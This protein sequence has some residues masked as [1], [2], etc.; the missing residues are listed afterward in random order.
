MRLP[1]NVPGRR[2]LR[3]LAPA[4][5]LC[6]APARAQVAEDCAGRLAR[7][8]QAASRLAEE[9][10]ALKAR[11]GLLEGAPALGRDEL[12]RRNALRLQGI[13]RDVKAQRQTM[14]DFERYVKWMSGSLSSYSRYIEAGTAA[15]TFAKYLPVPYAGQAGAFVKFAAHF[16][17]SLNATSNAIERYLQ[18]SQQF[19][20]RAEGL[21][22]SKPKE[23]EVADLGR[24]ADEQLLKATGDVQ[25]KLG[26]V[27]ELSASALS[28][29]QGMEQ[30]LSSADEA[31]SKTKQFVTRK[32]DDKKEKS[33]LAES[34]ENLKVQGAAFNG[35]F[36]LFEE[37]AGRNVPLV[38]SLGA[39]DELV[40][41]LDA[42]GPAPAR[43]AA[44]ATPR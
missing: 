11:I 39:Y 6:A 2:I 17:L 44:D 8:E 25:T 24:F 22:P 23:R 1:G 7:A 36:R 20:T 28:F 9:N 30:Y 31:W 13:A 34:I 26:T 3:A 18:T 12:V 27:S 4:L 32:D 16:A 29:L 37:S 41:E 15:A 33:F 10:A 38:K 19:V 40:R 14:A 21:D 43:P 5:L 42:K 35:R